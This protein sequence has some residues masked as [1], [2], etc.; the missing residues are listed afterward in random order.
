MQIAKEE[1]DIKFI[2]INTRNK[3]YIAKEIIQEIKDFTEIDYKIF[4][5]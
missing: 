1:K 2:Y 5:N 3:E 4:N